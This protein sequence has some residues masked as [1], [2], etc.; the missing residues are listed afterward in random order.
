MPRLVD[1]CKYSAASWKDSGWYSSQSPRIT[2]IKVS[3]P[4]GVSRKR[5]FLP[6]LLLARIF[7]NFISLAR[8]LSTVSF[9][10]DEEEALGDEEEEEETLEE[11]ES[12]LLLEA[13]PNTTSYN[14]LPMA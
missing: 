8:I 7:R 1:F 3:R 12:F 6:A 9:I 11:E 10:E 14:V 13:G 2:C 4:L 5:L